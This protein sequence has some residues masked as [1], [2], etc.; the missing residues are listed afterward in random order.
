MKEFNI[1]YYQCLCLGPVVVCKKQRNI[2]LNNDGRRVQVHR[3][4]RGIDR[5]STP[6]SS[7]ACEYDVIADLNSN[8]YMYQS[9]NVVIKS[10]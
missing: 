9:F 2:H 6:N 3:Y 4:G 7:T 1:Y 5:T 10:L 8:K